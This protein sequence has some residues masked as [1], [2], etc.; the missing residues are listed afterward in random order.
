MVSDAAT[1]ESHG[2]RDLT[3]SVA[4]VTGGG[5]GIGRAVA[6]A[7]AMRGASVV[8]CDIDAERLE[9]L[10]QETSGITAWPLDVTDRDAV[11]RMP[12]RLPAELAD[13][14][15]LVNA[16]GHD[17][18]GRRLFPTGE[19]DKYAHI[20]DTNVTGL[21]TMTLAFARGMSERGDGHIIN[22]GSSAGL[23]S[24]ATTSTYTASKHA[25]HG[26]SDSLRKDFVGTGVRVT[27]LNPGRVRTNF[28]YARAASREDGDAFYDQVGTCLTPD[29]IANAIVYA[30]TQPAHV[31][32]AQMVLMPSN[33]A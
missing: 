12:S 1:G 11:E 5:S 22:I 2:V 17:I 33:Q 26:F 8:A 31:V 27:E 14:D 19:A 18:G 7:L 13:V 6:V 29:D 21:I 16:A 24:E 10:A 30:L 28:G 25:V 20:I 32:V 9:S 3:Q 23:R 4:V 15:I